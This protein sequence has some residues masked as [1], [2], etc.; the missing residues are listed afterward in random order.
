M[1]KKWTVIERLV[2]D[3][4]LALLPAQS[5]GSHSVGKASE[6]QNPRAGNLQ[7]C[8]RPTWLIPAYLRQQHSGDR[9]SR[10]H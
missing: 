7:H 5:G 6:R 8:S 4:I 10:W 1:F 2:A 3:F 9:I